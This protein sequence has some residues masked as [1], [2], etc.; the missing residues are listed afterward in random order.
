MDTKKLEAL[1]TVIRHGSLTSAA[2]ELGYSQPGL[3]NMMNSIENEL[4]F[5]VLV[6]GKTGVRLSPA[7][8]E[9]FPSIRSLLE[10]TRNFDAA[11][12][13]IR[14]KA[15]F[16][17][18]VGAYSSIARQWLPE[19]MQ[20]FV[21]MVPEIDLSASIQDIKAMYD[22]V[23]NENLDCAIV[24]YAEN[25]MGNLSWTP[26][27][28]DEFVAVIPYDEEIDKSSL[29]PMRKF[30]GTSFLM[31][32]GG[33]DMDILPLFDSQ[34]SPGSIRY[35]NMDDET[36]ISMVE[37]NLGVTI[38]SR[39]IMQGNTS[40]VLSLPLDPSAHRNLGIIVKDKRKNER[41]VKLFVETALKTV[42]EK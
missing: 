25:L 42:K 6:R 8:Q 38:M 4:G 27:A 20:N 40:R 28:E 35:T 34:A 9:L 11:V 32:S 36:I 37:H 5:A 29:F 24:S 30:S 15:T 17:L 23:R 41:A 19:I 1:I 39:L 18:K 26:L 21:F 2:E 22:A 13:G 31:P 7:G 33:F 3:S 14:E 12:D 16:T 10:A